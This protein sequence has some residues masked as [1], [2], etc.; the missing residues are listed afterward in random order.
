MFR[1]TKILGTRVL[2]PT[3]LIHQSINNDLVTTT[4]IHSSQINFTDVL[5]FLLNL[6]SYNL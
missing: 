4:Q 5:R 6:H 1:A 3:K 2:A